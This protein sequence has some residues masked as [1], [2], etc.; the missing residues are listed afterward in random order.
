MPER[1]PHCGER[2]GNKLTRYRYIQPAG[3]AVDIRDKPHNNITVPQ[4]IPVRDPLIALE[5]ADWMPLPNP[6]L[7]RYRMT[8]QGSLFHHSAGLNNQGYA[9]C[10]RCG[11]ADSENEQEGVLPTIFKNHKRLRGGRLNDRE[12]SVPAMKNPVG[13]F[14]VECD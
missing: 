2:D 9:L 5:D 13:Q 10:L 8:M 11:L 12:K 1:C 14:C 6:A 3:F 7:G 4:Y